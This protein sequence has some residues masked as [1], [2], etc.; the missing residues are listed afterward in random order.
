MLMAISESEAAV[1]ETISQT[2]TQTRI[3]SFF[4]MI[5]KGKKTLLKTSVIFRTLI[6]SCDSLPELL[7]RLRHPGPDVRVVGVAKHRLVQPPTPG[8]FARGV[9]GRGG[10]R[11]GGLRFL[12]IMFQLGLTFHIWPQQLLEGFYSVLAGKW[13]LHAGWVFFAFHQNSTL[14]MLLALNWLTRHLL[15][16]FGLKYATKSWRTDFWELSWNLLT[17]CCSYQVLRLT[18]FYTDKFHCINCVDTR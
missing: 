12:R 10:H 7:C 1:N 2:L 8:G 18:T 6:V 9:A 5:S 13:T 14:H 16:K 11:P 15:T 3:D 17:K 4:S